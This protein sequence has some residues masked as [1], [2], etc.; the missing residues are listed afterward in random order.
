MLE[1]GGFP[2]PPIIL[3]FILGPMIEISLRRGLMLSRGSLVPFFTR[4]ICLTFLL[5]TAV[6]IIMAVRRELRPKRKAAEE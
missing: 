4:P 1:R 6:V 3:G 5:I 2:L